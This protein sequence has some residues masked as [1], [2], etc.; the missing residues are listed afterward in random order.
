M[1]GAEI[2]QLLLIFGPKGIELIEKLIS[3]WTKQMTPE[4]VLAITALAKKTYQEYLDEAGV[5]TPP[6]TT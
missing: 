1:T 3:V 6:E 5:V 4:E 2:V